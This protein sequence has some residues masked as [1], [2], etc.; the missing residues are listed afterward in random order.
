MNNNL[1]GGRGGGECDILFQKTIEMK[2]KVSV[3]LL[4]YITEKI[5]QSFIIWNN[6]A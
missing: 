3:M 5:I 6:K 1:W 4:K 2:L